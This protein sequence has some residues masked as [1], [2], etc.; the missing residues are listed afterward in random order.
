MTWRN[1]K[2]G[3]RMRLV[4]AACLHGAMSSGLRS[5]C[6]HTVQRRHDGHSARGTRTI[7]CTSLLLPTLAQPA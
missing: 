7:L 4:H 1:D 6:R 2:T 3:T 5:T